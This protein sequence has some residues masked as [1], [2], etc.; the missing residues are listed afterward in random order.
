MKTIEVKAV[1][2]DNFGKKSSKAVRSQGQI[3]CVIY[4]NG[5]TLHCSIDQTATRDIIFTP[6][7]FIIDLDFGTSKESVVMREVQYH[8]I[9]DNALHID[10]YRISKTKP[11]TIEIPVKLTGVAEG[12]KTGGKLIL[13]KRKLRVS[14]LV[15]N[16]PDELNVDVTKL[17]LGKSIFVSDVKIPNLTI[18]TP[19]STAICAVKMTRAARGA[20]ATDTS[21]PAPAAASAATPAK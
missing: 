13:S 14:G 7:A 8:P 5:E 17:E 10:F 11:I 2:R 19:A 3:P 9:G 21:T 16:L 15:S 18:L 12:V 1:K 20:A 6:S 4:G